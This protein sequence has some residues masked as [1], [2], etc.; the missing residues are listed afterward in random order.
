MVTMSRSS[1][2]EM[3]VAI[4]EPDDAGQNDLVGSIAILKRRWWLLVLIPLLVA[5]GAH[6]LVPLRGAT[7]NATAS[8]L[9]NP[10]GAP[11][12]NPA[13]DATAATILTQTYRELAISAPVLQR[14]VTDLKL[15]ETATDLESLVTATADP[16]SQIIRITTKYPSPQMAANISNAIGDQFVA[17]LADLQRT[18]TPQNSQALRDS[19]EKAR[20]DRDNAAAQLATLRGIEG[21]P[22]PEQNVRI[23][24]LESLLE[25]YQTAYSGL[26]DFQQHV[27]LAQFS[28]ATGVRV[29]VRATPPQN[30]A[31]SRQLLTTAGALLAALGL[32]AVGIVLLEQANP[33]IRSRKDIQRLADLPLLATVP[34]TRHKN[35]IE[36]RDAPR[37]VMSEAI[38]ALQAKIWLEVR[39]NAATTIAITN[40]GSGDGATA[41]AVNLAVAFAQTGQRVVLVDGNLRNPSHWKLF[42]KDA[43]HPGLAELVAVPALTPNDVLTD[44]P[45]ENLRLLLAGPVSRIPTERLTSQRLENIVANLRH[46]AD[47]V[48]IDAPPPQ[49]NSDTLLYAAAADDAIVVAHADRTPAGTLRTTLASIRAMKVHMLGL[50]LYGADRDGASE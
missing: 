35:G 42:K 24:N 16:S 12:D 34:R 23:A 6:E 46:R 22:T 36:T 49:A 5:L 10:A 43:K 33:R 20:A 19:I 45:H 38:H 13:N 11:S 29:A 50:V 44:G 47:I 48:I 40:P 3:D 17:F 26:L 31:G 4:N 25:Q 21:T 32:T 30:P 27:N 8:L 18:G 28:P 39:D 1:L 14:V 15:P 41:V 37:S 2:Q 9:V 7:Y